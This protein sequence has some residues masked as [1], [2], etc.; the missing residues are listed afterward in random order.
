MDQFCA[1][2]SY[3]PITCSVNP[4]A[5]VDNKG[6][7][8]SNSADVTNS[9]SANP[10]DGVSTCTNAG[11]ACTNTVNPV[12]VNTGMLNPTSTI[13]STGATTIVTSAKIDSKSSSMLGSKLGIAETPGMNEQHFLG[14]QQSAKQQQFSPNN[15]PPDAQ[16]YS[17][18]NNLDA[19]QS[20]YASRQQCSPNNTPLDSQY[21]NSNTQDSNHFHPHTQSA[22]QVY[23][24]LCIYIYRHIYTHIITTG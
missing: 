20:Q 11:S 4:S 10:A 22:K 7:V 6:G 18:N 17:N 8:T 16:K 14:Q 24:Y 19:N 12:G 13:G 2:C 9:V 21:S 1:A 3:L 15:T 5:D 23:M